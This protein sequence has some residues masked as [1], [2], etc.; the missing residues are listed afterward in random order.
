MEFVEGGFKSKSKKKQGKKKAGF[1]FSAA[2]PS[3]P[4]ALPVF[5]G[6][7]AQRCLRC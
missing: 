6:G 1:N 4:Y 5:I 3:R 2:L 7:V